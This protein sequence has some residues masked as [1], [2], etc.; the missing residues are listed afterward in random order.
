[1]I[2]TTSLRVTKLKTEVQALLAIRVDEV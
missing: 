1:V 2:Q